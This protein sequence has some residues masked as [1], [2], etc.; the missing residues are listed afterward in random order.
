MNCEFVNKIEDI[1]VNSQWK[2]TDKISSKYGKP[3]QVSH[4]GRLYEVV[5]HY[6]R[7][8]T[9]LERLKRIALGIWIVMQSFGSERNSKKVK[10]LFYKKCEGKRFAIPKI[11]VPGFIPDRNGPD[12]TLLLDKGVRQH[13]YSFLD[14]DSLSKCLSVAKSWRNVTNLKKIKT[15]FCQKIAIGKRAWDEIGDIGSVPPL[16]NHI[17]DILQRP[18]PFFLKKKI[19]ETHMLVLIPETINGKD[20]NLNVFESFDDK[21]LNETY[22]INIRNRVEDLV[23][24]DIG[25]QTKKSHWVL[26]SREAIFSSKKGYEIGMY[27]LFSNEIKAFIEEY[28][29]KSGLKYEVPGALDVAT[30][31]F[32]DRSRIIEQIGKKN[33]SLGSL[34]YCRESILNKT[35]GKDLGIAKAGY[36]LYGSLDSDI[37]YS[38]N[39]EI[40]VCVFESILSQGVKI[41]I[42]PMIRFD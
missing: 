8:Y 7:Q 16:P 18:C 34:T 21:Y 2:K 36:S 6:E 4:K 32:M 22:R 12:L 28:Q 41:G 39:F 42:T 33:I 38:P 20:Y 15:E 30:C 35:T 37:D 23:L 29:K 26:I 5:A 14:T 1:Q 11:N 25:N 9:F 17:Y 3:I 31:F 24:K 10:K 27:S 19:V 40:Q 13:L